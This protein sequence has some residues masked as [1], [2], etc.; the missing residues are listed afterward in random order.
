MDNVECT[1]DIHSDIEFNEG[2]L[3]LIHEKKESQMERLDEM[4]QDREGL[5]QELLEA[6]LELEK[7]QADSEDYKQK[8]SLEL[9][10][11]QGKELVE[12]E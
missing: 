9:R 7:S 11:A 4:C 10:D 5:S 2:I 6:R 3:P 12:L 8:S 1:G